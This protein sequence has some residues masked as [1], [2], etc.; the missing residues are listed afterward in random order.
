MAKSNHT[1][2]VDPSVIPYGSKVVINGKIY[3]AE[4]CGGAIKQN[5]IDIYFD[6]HEEASDFGVQYAEVYLV[7]E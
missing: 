6:T 1:I 2:A 5:C 7:V 3:V 4:D